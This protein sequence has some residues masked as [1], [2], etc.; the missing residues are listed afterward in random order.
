MNIK[1]SK[2][3]SVVWVGGGGGG[4]RME[5]GGCCGVDEVPLPRI[6]LTYTTS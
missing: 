4:R 6:S 2:V 3:K 5:G 1:I